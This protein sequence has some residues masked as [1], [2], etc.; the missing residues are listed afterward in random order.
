MSTAPVRPKV[1]VIDEVLRRKNRIPVQDT[2]TFLYSLSNALSLA[3]ATA[4][5][6]LSRLHGCME[7]VRRNFSQWIEE[8]TAD[9]R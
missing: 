5:G 7:R 4:D 1:G 9:T 3:G 6:L 2:P 8:W